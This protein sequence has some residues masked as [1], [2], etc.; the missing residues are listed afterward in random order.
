M[1][2]RRG[3]GFPFA[4]GCAILENAEILI[5]NSSETVT[6]GGVQTVTEAQLAN[7]LYQ[8]GTADPEMTWGKVAVL[9]KGCTYVVA[10]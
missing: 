6:A 1:A 9:H 2:P 5:A 4:H 7:A 8:G 10:G 3:K